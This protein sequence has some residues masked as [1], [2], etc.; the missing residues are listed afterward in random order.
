MARPLEFLSSFKSR[1]TPLEVQQERPDSFPDEAGKWTLIS[2]QGGENGALLGLWRD[3]GSSS[4]VDTVMSGNFLSCIMGVKDTF[5]ASRGKVEFLSRCSGKGPILAFSGESPGF[6]RV[7]AGNL[8]FLSSYNRDIW[9]HLYCL[10]KVQFP[11]K[12]PG[13]YQDSSPVGS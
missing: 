2:R 1:L 9:D 3:T 10:R 6:S 5:E 7:V 13:T 4:G 11:C 12:L 8:G